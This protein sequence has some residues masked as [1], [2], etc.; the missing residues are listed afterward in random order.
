MTTTHENPFSPERLQRLP[1]RFSGAGTWENLLAR[2]ETN[3]HCA[4]IVGQAGTG[5]TTLLHQLA[6]RL[7]ERGFVPRLFELTPESGMSD[8]E[9]LVEAVREIR[10]PEIILLDGAERLTTRQW[11]PL[12]AAASQAAGFIVTLYRVGR[13]PTLLECETSAGLLEELVHDLAE[14]RLPK[15][16][17]ATVMTRHRGNLREVLRELHDRWAGAES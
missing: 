3:Q 7:S 8:R 12:R 1:F 6:E 14:S 15:G 4:A 13:L 16:E 9:Q 5:K 17:A 10:A 11:L 2:L